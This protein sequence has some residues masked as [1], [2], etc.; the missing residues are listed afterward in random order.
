MITHNSRRVKGAKGEGEVM[1]ELHQ[2]MAEE[3]A[4]ANL[5]LPE[6]T[7]G[8]TG[9]DIRGISFLAPEIKRHEPMGGAVEI[10]PTQLNAW[11]EQAKRQAGPNQMPAL[12]WRRNYAPWKVRIYGY[13]E[14]SERRRIKTPVDISME[15]FLIWFRERVRESLNL[16]DKID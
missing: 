16:K 1:V 15:T 5:P 8:R 2:I 10:L 6:I 3:Y 9:R 7:R 13:L 4:K 12:F 14:L 11:W